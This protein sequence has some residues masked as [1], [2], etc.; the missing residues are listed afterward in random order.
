MPRRYS[1]ANC[2]SNENGTGYVF[3]MVNH[4][5]K[6][7]QI[8]SEGFSIEMMHG[9]WREPSNLLNCLSYLSVNLDSQLSFIL[10]KQSNK[11]ARKTRLW[12]SMELEIWRSLEKM[13]LMGQ[14]LQ[15][16]RAAL[17]SLLW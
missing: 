5:S 17:S 1:V 3:E 14:E 10:M 15:I 8:K 6:E 11:S 7:M 2:C 16:T 12:K 4:W 9:N 13:G